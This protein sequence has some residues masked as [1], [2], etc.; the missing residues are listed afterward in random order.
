MAY[1]NAGYF[2][3]ELQNIELQ[4]LICNLI[5]STFVE[6]GNIFIPSI[7]RPTIDFEDLDNIR[8]DIGQGFSADG[9]DPQFK[10]KVVGLP[11]RWANQFSR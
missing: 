10:F 1:W 7:D 6:T 9:N 5:I 4:E 11:M 2:G 3:V 8:Y